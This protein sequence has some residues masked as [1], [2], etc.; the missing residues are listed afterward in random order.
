ME[1][2]KLRSHIGADGVLQIQ[3]FTALKDTLVEVVVIV[4]PLPDTE[5]ALAEEAQS[6]CNAWGKKVTKESIGN[7]IAKMQQLRRE[8]ALDKMSVRSM[9]DEGRR[10]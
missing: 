8:V 1:T 10:F 4:Q 9:I 3:T 5:A 2:K 7:A 6:R